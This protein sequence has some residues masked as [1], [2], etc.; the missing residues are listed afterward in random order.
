M[1]RPIA[2]ALAA[3]LPL[4]Y[5]LWLSGAVPAPLAFGAMLGF[6][7]V[8][9]FAGQLCLR[10]ARAED[11]PIA[12]AWVFGVF[13]SALAVYALV[14]GLGM[15]AAPAFG[16]WALLVAAACIA[17]RPRAAARPEA[18]ELLG[19]LLCGVATLAWC[20][21][22]A[23]I[24]QVFARERLLPAW[25]DYLIHGGVVSQF[26]DPRAARQS[27]FLADYPLPAYHFASYMLPA[28]L[29]GALDLPGLP[30]AT[31]L[32]LPIGFLTLCAGAY[33]LGASL[34]GPAG[35]IAAVASLTVLPDAANYWLRNGFLSFHW[36]LLALP[37]GAYGTGVFMLAFA[38]LQRWMEGAN[39]R[40]LWAAVGLAAGAAVFRV[41][42]FAVG[43]PA[44]VLAAVLTLHWVRTH[45]VLAFCA[46]LVGFAAF[47]GV[48]YVATDSLP[49]LELTLDAIH[50]RQEPTGYSRFYP[51]LLATYGRGVA[52]AIGV[53]LMLAAFLGAFAVLYPL[54]ALLAR[55]GGALR[56]IDLAPLSLLVCYVLLVITAPMVHW[57]AT[58]LTVRPFVLIYAVLAVW[59]AATLAR[60]LAGRPR[61]AWAW[62]GLLAATALALLLVWPQTGKMGLLPKFGWG[63]LFYPLRVQQGIPEAGAF[64]RQHGAPGDLLAVSGLPLDWAPT[65]PGIQLVALSGIPA[66]LAYTISQTAD[67]GPR[68]DMA[69]ARFLELE[70]VAQ[71]PDAAQA[72]A[73]LHGLGIRWYVVVGDAGPG[74]DPQRKL[75]AFVSGKTAVYSSRPR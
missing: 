55:R 75:A 20:H 47:V 68:R 71:A 32:W 16:V 63:W 70:R 13:V 66:Y 27:I 4:S 53:P 2:A 3:A 38:L 65:D 1:S 31:S 29:A 59:T 10:A 11:M 54:S 26:G 28:A 56:A 14:F 21:E 43:F 62:P 41:H 51:Y 6:S 72:Q 64:L 18:K 7:L 69:V 58:E 22:V 42:L 30:G 44:V 8:V 17:W 40:A 24:P 19:L 48:F 74:W 50:E 25:I 39:R 61:G 37:G 23:E 9:I 12:A 35:G 34:G 73:L 49:G 5:L 57:D 36:H 52:I 15:R 46:A 33:L 67:P 60:W 45:K